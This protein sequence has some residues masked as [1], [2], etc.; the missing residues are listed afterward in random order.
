MRMCSLMGV[1][2]L[3]VVASTA[4]HGG[5]L[6]LRPP[7]PAMFTGPGA[8]GDGEYTGP[9]TGP[10]AVAPGRRAARMAGGCP[11]AADGSE[12]GITGSVT[13]GIG[14]SSRGGTSHW[15]AADMNLCK[16]RVNADG[17]VSTMNLNLRVGRYDGPGM[18]HHGLH[19]G[20]FGPG[21]EFGP[22]WHSPYDPWPGAAMPRR[23]SWSEGRRPWR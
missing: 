8:C 20:G 15:N 6:D 22:G 12:R 23:E 21:Y 2:L 7:A 14:H 10:S 3:L 16:E 19:P 9:R 17:D 13:T 11:T 1:S 18:Y 4:A 5:D